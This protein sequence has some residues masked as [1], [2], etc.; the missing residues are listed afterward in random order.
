MMVCCW[1]RWLYSLL[2]Y[3]GDGLLNL[4]S[5][6]CFQDL[7][8]HF[9]IG[10]PFQQISKPLPPC[11]RT[12]RSDLGAYPIR[13]PISGLISNGALRKPSGRLFSRSPGRKAGGGNRLAQRDHEAAPR[14][15]CDFPAAQPRSELPQT[16]KLPKIQSPG[17]WHPCRP[18]SLEIEI[19][20]KSC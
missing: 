15:R 1:P 19:N 8:A 9:G 10:R 2:R 5:W 13:V 16:P 12:A 11:G 14:W 20:T 18:R 4:E 6:F 17:I 7:P 3:Y